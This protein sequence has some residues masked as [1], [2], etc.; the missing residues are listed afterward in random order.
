MAVFN[1]YAGAA[2]NYP[3]SV[4]TAEYFSRLHHLANQVFDRHTRLYAYT[5][6]EES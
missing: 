4:N 6:L 2:R 1:V 5:T 3:C